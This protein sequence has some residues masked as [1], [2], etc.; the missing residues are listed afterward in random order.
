M[1]KDIRRRFVTPQG[2]WRPISA[3]GTELFGL[4]T[5]VVTRNRRRGA[6]VPSPWPTIKPTAVSVESRMR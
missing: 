3:D 1:W 5:V 4:Q 6:K 2:Y